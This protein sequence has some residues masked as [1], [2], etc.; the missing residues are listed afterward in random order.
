MVTETPRTNDEENVAKKQLI[1]FTDLT[2]SAS[3]VILSS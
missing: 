2:T 3:S 1:L